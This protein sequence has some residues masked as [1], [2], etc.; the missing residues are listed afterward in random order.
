VRHVAAM[1]PAASTV[2]DLLEEQRDVD[3]ELR[4]L[5]RL[6]LGRRVMLAV[7][8]LIVVGAAVGLSGERTRTASAT[9]GGYTLEV[10]YPSLVRDGPPSSPTVTVRHPPGFDE[11]A[12]CAGTNLRVQAEPAAVR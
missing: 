1:S 5:R 12:T 4:R 10:R 9:G 2:D 6:R 3:G 7:L 8:V 11:T